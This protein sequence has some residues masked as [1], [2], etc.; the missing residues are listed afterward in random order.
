MFLIVDWYKNIKDYLSWLSLFI[1][2][3][4]Y[5]IFQLFWGLE[6]IALEDYRLA[7]AIFLDGNSGY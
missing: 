7:Y 1:V 6:S 5:F 2:E 3:L 4:H